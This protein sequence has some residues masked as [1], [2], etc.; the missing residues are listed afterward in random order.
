MSAIAY[1]FL[2]HHEDI[3]F[4]HLLPTMLYLGIVFA[5]TVGLIIIGHVAKKHFPYWNMTFI[6]LILGVAD[7]YITPHFRE[8]S[9]FY[10][11]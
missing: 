11:F 8:Y 6:P 5:Y 4:Y 9:A 1:V 3:V 2:T 7:V 10:Q